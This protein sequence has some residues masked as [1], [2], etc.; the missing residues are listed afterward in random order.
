MVRQLNPSAAGLSARTVPAEPLEDPGSRPPGLSERLAR[1]AHRYL[2]PV[3]GAGTS[4]LGIGLWVGGSGSDRPY[5]PL[6]LVGVGIS[7]IATSVALHLRPHSRATVPAPSRLPSAASSD[8][9]EPGIAPS[10]PRSGIGRAVTSSE[11]VRRDDIWRSWEVPSQAPLGAAL[12]GP[13]AESAYVPE[14]DPPVWTDVPRDAEHPLL[15]M[16]ARPRSAPLRGPVGVPGAPRYAPAVRALPSFRTRRAARRRGPFSEAELDRLFPLERPAAL[17]VPPMPLATTEISPMP[18][19]RPAL[20]LEADAIGASDTAAARPTAAPPAGGA[21][22]VAGAALEPV[23]GEQPNGRFRILPS[24][25]F[26]RNPLYLE[27]I[28]P[29][30][31]HLRRAGRSGGPVPGSSAAAPLDRSGGL[32][33][34]CVGCLRSFSGFR[35]WVLCPG[36]HAP[37]CRRCLGASFLASP[38]GQCSRC[39][40][41]HGR[42]AN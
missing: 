19:L 6:A 32:R 36:C 24:L 16:V 37:L 22:P 21:S 12:T 23:T 29:L 40:P 2:V 26:L 25:L 42:P 4:A 9:L 28:Q 27:A 35:S 38:E 8:A 5:L 17:H 39:H 15:P 41:W 1:A 20:A 34:E 7:A 11:V 13:V 33:V 14:M 31:P 30:P 10:V 3:A 18:F